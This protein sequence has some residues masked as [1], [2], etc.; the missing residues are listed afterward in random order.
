MGSSK[1]VVK[2]E[3]DKGYSLVNIEGSYGHFKIKKYSVTKDQIKTDSNI[4]TDE[5]ISINSSGELTFIVN[6]KKSSEVADWWSKEIGAKHCTFNEEPKELNFGVLGELEINVTGGVFGNNTKIIKYEDVALAQGHTASRNNW[7]FGGKHFL[8]LNQNRAICSNEEKIECTAIRGTQYTEEFEVNIVHLV[9][10]KNNSKI[11]WMNNVDE[12]VTLYHMSIP[13]THDSGTS[14][15]PKLAANCQNFNIKQQLLSG[16]RVFDIR[17]NAQMDLCHS[18]FDSVENW[19]EV[20]YNDFIPFLEANPSEFIVMLLGC[21]NTVW[22]E[23]MRQTVSD[24]CNENN[25]RICF[26]EQE[27]CLLSNLKSLRQKIIVLKRQE[28]CPFGIRLKFEDNQTFTY[29]NFC[30]EDEYK[31]YDTSKKAETVKSNIEKADSQY[32]QFIKQ[33]TESKKS[34]DKLSST[35]Y[36]TFH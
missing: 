33:E 28:D 34:S 30:V 9:D 35:L 6:R 3:L 23:F 36:I 21:E 31:Q 20:I 8:Y 14:S 16:I 27:N 7:W 17:V 1:N 19:N 5:V 26:L 18:V 4:K 24:T 13:G 25:S 32:K 15:V 11:K 12:N 29:K 2:F 22:T 10:F